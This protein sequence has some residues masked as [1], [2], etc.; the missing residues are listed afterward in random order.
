[1]SLLAYP[2]MLFML[3]LAA[4]VH[5]AIGSLEVEVENISHRF[6]WWCQEAQ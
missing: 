5:V 1:M 2:R 3:T 4:R 6:Y